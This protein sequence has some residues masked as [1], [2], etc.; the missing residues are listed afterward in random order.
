MPRAEKIKIGD[1]FLDNGSITEAQLKQALVHQKINGGK[2]GAILVQLNIATE[3]Q[4]AE[5]LSVQLKIP[6]IELEFYDIKPEVVRQIPEKIARHHRLLLLSKE[7]RDN[8]V[9]MAD[10]TDLVALDEASRVLGGTIKM[11]AVCESDLLNILDQVYRRTEDIVSFAKELQEEIGTGS[12]EELEEELQGGD[13]DAPVAKLLDSIFTDAVQIRASDIHIEPDYNVVRIRLRVDGVLQEDIIDGLGIIGPL[14]LRLKLMAKLDISEKRLPQDG[15]FQIKSSG[16]R[17]DVRISTIPLQNG[18]GVVMRLLDQTEGILQ[19]DKIGLPDNI[20]ER[21]RFSI[22]RPSGLVLVTGPTGSGKT[23]TLY[24]CLTELNSKEKKIL[25]IEDPIEYVLPRVN[26]IQVQANINLTFSAV[27][28]AALRQ[29]PDIIMIGE[30]RDE[31]TARI[32]VRAA[33]TGHL[34][35]STLHTNDAISSAIRV[36]DMGV[37]GYLVASALRAITAQRLVKKV[38]ETCREPEALTDEVKK[39]LKM[40]I[41]KVEDSWFL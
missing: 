36:I 13:K 40:I 6:F 15:R 12:F 30:M 38:C 23:T 11:A 3:R 10:P 2:L 31:E 9:A 28:R 1:L 7:K 35:L 5:T 21:L 41:G 39:K 4:F 17:L 33:M 25:T 22:T 19:L 18:E 27:L 16:H 20:V 8:L 14:V 24:A 34:V 32:G 37:E 29:D 26:Q